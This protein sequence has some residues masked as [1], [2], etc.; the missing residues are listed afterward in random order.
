MKTRLKGLFVL[1]VPL[2]AISACISLP[3][4]LGGAK[5][6]APEAIYTLHAGDTPFG[7]PAKGGPVVVVPKPELPAGFDTERIALHFDDG[8]RLDYYADAKWSA[9]LDA[10][11]QDFMVQK[12]KQKMP[13]KI[14]GTPDLGSSAKYKLALKFNEFGPVYEGMP[15]K[16]P[17]L[18][19][20]VTVTVISM[21]RETVAAQFTLKKSA[22]VAANNL[23][24]ITGGLEKL[25]QE[26]TD[27][28]LRRAAPNLG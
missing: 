16:P 28:V 20:G 17:R 14:V 9:R 18:D 12:V 3:P 2:L 26:V 6:S 27:E 22:P 24:T 4:L 5:E 10:L 15:D 1:L 23:T 19:V 13:Q 7:V 11:L 25:L 8:R 21:P